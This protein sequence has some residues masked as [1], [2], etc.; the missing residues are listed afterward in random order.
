[1]EG[2][3]SVWIGG[4]RVRSVVDGQTGS[5]RLLRVRHKECVTGVVPRHGGVH[6][7]GADTGDVL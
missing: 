6:K 1:M 2:G 5:I 4:E 3:V 7:V